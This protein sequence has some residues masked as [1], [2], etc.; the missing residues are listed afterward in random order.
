MYICITI[1]NTNIQGDEY[2][3]LKI[4]MSGSTP[5]YQQIRNQIVFGIATGKLR[6]GD[7]LPTIRQLANEIGVNPMTVSKS[8]GMLKDEGV[9]LMDR[10]HGAQ[11]NRPQPKENALDIDF[12]HAAMLLISEAYTKG[13]SREEL[14]KHILKLI[15]NIYVQ[16][17][18]QS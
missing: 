14:E 1:S 7:K 9:I 15:N 6:A 10:R 13:V 4:D 2:V 5:I 17:E 8:Y 18:E 12:D 3:R 16:R 11:V